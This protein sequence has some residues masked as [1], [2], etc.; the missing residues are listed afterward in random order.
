MHEKLTWV[1]CKGNT[2]WSSIVN[3]ELE[4]L[5]FQ[6]SA[7]ESVSWYNVGKLSRNTLYMNYSCSITQLIL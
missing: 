5:K 2:Q 7:N 3:K 6:C 1:K 4:K